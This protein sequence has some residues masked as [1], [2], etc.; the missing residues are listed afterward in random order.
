MVGVEGWNNL[1]EIFYIL[2]NTNNYVILRDFENDLSEYSQNIKNNS[3]SLD[4]DILSENAEDAKWIL[5]VNK[6]VDKCFFSNLKNNKIVY[7]DIKDA[8]SG[9][10]CNKMSIDIL[11]SKKMNNYYFVPNSEYH[12]YSCLYHSLVHKFNFENEYNEILEYIFGKRTH[13]SKKDVKYYI[14]KCSDW[15]MKKNYSLDVYIDE[16][17][18]FN[19]NNIKQF[20]FNLNVNEVIYKYKFLMTYKEKLFNQFE[21]YRQENSRLTS[22]LNSLYNSRSWRVTKPLRG[23]RRVVSN[24]KKMVGTK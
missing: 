4:I 21:E 6:T 20:N 3:S 10:Y 23:I 16:F 1:E 11:N 5:N 17:E 2:N 22:E 12:Y 15:L 18:K 7:F 24:S 9:Y 19:I 14:S 13:N 8:R